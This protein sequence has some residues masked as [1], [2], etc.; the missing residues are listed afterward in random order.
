M[1]NDNPVGFIEARFKTEIAYPGG[2]FARLA[3]PPGV[4]MMGFKPDI[5][6]ENSARKP[7]EKDARDEPIQ[8]TFVGKNDI[9]PGQ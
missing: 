2:S 8:I 3:L 5:D 4:V 1:I 6:V 9:R 7:L